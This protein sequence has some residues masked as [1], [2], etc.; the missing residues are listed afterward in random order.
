VMFSSSYLELPSQTNSGGTLLPLCFMNL[1]VSLQRT[2]SAV[3]HALIHSGRTLSPVGIVA[4]TN[5]QPF[6]AAS[7]SARVLASACAAMRVARSVKETLII[8]LIPSV[9]PRWTPSRQFSEAI[10]S[11][12]IGARTEQ[13]LGRTGEA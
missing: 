8:R 12:S 3:L 6:S 10:I 11:K 7:S 5:A 9:S 13:N 1:A 2:G 4:E